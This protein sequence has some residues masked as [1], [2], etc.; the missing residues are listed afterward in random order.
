MT[1]LKLLSYNIHKGFTAGNRAFVLTHIR[2]SIRLAGADLVCLQ[3]VLGKHSHPSAKIFDWP[4]TSQFEF[5]A[6]ELWPHYAYGCNSVY[7]EGHHGNAILSRFP[8]R[9]H[10]NHNISTN[11][12]ENRGMLHA[13][14]DLCPGVLHVINMHLD[15]LKSGR[16][17]QI[18][19]LCKMVEQ[20][21]EVDEP[22][23]IAGDFND[24]TGEVSK[25]LKDRMGCNEAFIASGGKHAR[26]FPAAFP[27]LS[28]D[29]IYARNVEIMSATTLAEGVWKS[30]SDHAAILGEFE[31]ARFI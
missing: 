7:E 5:L 14:I 12:L 3:E 11:F 25:M 8:I 16:R 21:I 26:T 30:L 31:V 4:T 27:L 2:E 6:D 9:L 13:E 24:W 1:I 29:R 19:Q 20:E 17:K 28:L 22:L 23:F 15:L 10:K 18:D